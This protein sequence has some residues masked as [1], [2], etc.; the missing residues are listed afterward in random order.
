[1]IT[2]PE[3]IKNLLKSDSAH[4]NFRVHFPNG[5]REDITNANIVSESVTLTESICSSQQLKIGMCETPSIEFETIGVPY[6]KGAEIECSLE[7]E[8]PQY[9]RQTFYG[10]NIF[11][12]G[13]INVRPSVWFGEDVY[14][15]NVFPIGSDLNIE[16]RSVIGED[17]KFSTVTL[18]FENT[19]R[20]VV[21]RNIA[22]K[23]ITVGTDTPSADGGISKV[24][25]V[26]TNS[27]V[28]VLVRNE[29]D[30][31][32]SGVVYKEDIGKYV[33]PIP[34]GTYLVDSCKKQADMSHRRIVAYNKL[35]YKSWGLNSLIKHA[36]SKG[37][38]WYTNT[39]KVGIE[40]LVKLLIPSMNAN[41]Q[42]MTTYG[43]PDTVSDSY[44]EWEESSDSV[45]KIYTVEL[46]IQHF[47]TGNVNF[48]YSILNYKLDYDDDFIDAIADIK[49]YLISLG[50]ERALNV[51]YS[52]QFDPLCLE[53]YHFSS[54][55]G[56]YDY[57]LEM[58]NSVFQGYLYIDEIGNPFQ[59]RK[60]TLAFTTLGL[61]STY[62]QNQSMWQTW[63]YASLAMFTRVRV[64][65]K[66]RNVETGIETEETILKDTGFYTPMAYE[67]ANAKT[68]NLFDSASGLY[69]NLTSKKKSITMPRTNL[70]S[71]SSGTSQKKTLYLYN[72]NGL[73]DIDYKTLI[74]AYCEI[75]GKF[76]LITR[77]GDINFVSVN[78]AFNSPDD[79]VSKND[80]YTLWYDDFPSKPYGRISASYKDSNGDEIYT[81]YDLVEN[82]SDADYKTYDISNNYFIKNY[83]HT[84]EQMQTIFQTMGANM[85]D[86]SYMPMNLSMKGRPDL[87]AGDVVIVNS[88]EQQ[89]TG[90]IMQRTI[91]GI[92]GLTDEITSQ[93][94]TDQSL[95]SS[96][97]TIYDEETGTL[98][99]YLSE[100]R[101]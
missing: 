56:D 39:L 8:C 93:D 51:N 50:L 94:D 30:V 29:C 87:E 20:T 69:I 37:M 97:N 90:F 75:Q 49:E 59:V 71:G 32:I 40:G 79:T 17:A 28:N 2:I 64:L 34:Y 3:S 33:Y 54:S 27:Q 14:P 58:P 63:N 61:A 26:L 55:A 83:V 73:F 92:V 48:P 42:E 46:Q 10:S 76:G 99:L 45:Q 52:Q 22:Y 62:E 23:H 12:S 91:N 47:H 4:K 11:G 74:Q 13:T 44:V 21:Y 81:S 57:M 25:L 65:Y 100:T 43:D 98:S 36:T 5:E 72:F 9:E 19:S 7:V 38:Y 16:C 84:E 66:E 53:Y 1:M 31:A 41:Y 86:I 70:P 78:E 82:F 35:A 60:G 6:I 24:E 88:D 80:Y 67:D 85:T 101:R 18:Y 68:M 96:L 15:Y 95:L 77:D 89:I